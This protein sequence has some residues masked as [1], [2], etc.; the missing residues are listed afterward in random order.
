M[1]SPASFAE[2]TASTNDDAKRALAA[3]SPHGALFVAERQT[4]GRGRQ[5]RSWQGEAGASLLFSLVVRCP[6]APH[7]SG[8]IPVAA[9]LALA[10]AID[11]VAGRAVARVKWPNDVRIAGRK[12][13]GILADATVRAGAIEGIVV[14]VGVNV[15]AVAFAGELE[16]RA[17]SLANEGVVV[18]RLDVLERFCVRFE[19]LVE[20]AAQHGLRDFA[21]RIAAKHELFGS[22][23]RRSDGV[24]AEADRIDDEGRLVVRQGGA[25]ER[26]SSGEVH[27]VSAEV[28]S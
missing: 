27:L 2:E 16:G 8:A 6:V 9:G 17:T 22:R 28:P 24:E 13:A 20:R 7:A 15:G 10:E 14:G 1:G 5:G 25:I 4:A 26:W 11:D 21:A 18:S 23:V 3:G 12:V 19:A